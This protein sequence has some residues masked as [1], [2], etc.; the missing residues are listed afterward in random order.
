MALR[1]LARLGWGLGAGATSFPPCQRHRVNRLYE[2]RSLGTERKADAT[3]TMPGVVGRRKVFR[4][5]STPP[6][7]IKLDTSETKFG[8]LHE[9]ESVFTFNLD[10]PIGQFNL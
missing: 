7:F 1:W 2:L 6:F 8:L 3:S 4:A 9:P 10:I 5:L